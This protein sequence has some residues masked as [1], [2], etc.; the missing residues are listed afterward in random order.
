[1][2]SESEYEAEALSM[3][4]QYGQTLQIAGNGL[5]KCPYIFKEQYDIGDTITL[6]FSG[7]SA[8]AQI[9]TVTEHWTWGQYGIEFSFGKPQNDLARQLQLILKQIQKASNKTSTTSSVKYYTIPTDT[10]QP[11]A[12]VIYDTIGFQGNVGNGAAFTLYYDSEKTGAKN[13]HI[14]FKQLAGTGKLTLTTGVAGASNL[15][16]NAGTYVALIYVDA[17]GNVLSQGATATD[18]IASG[19]TQPATSSGVAGAISTE[20]TDR[21]NA[22]STAIGTIGNVYQISGT[23]L[24]MNSC[25]IDSLKNATIFYNI[26]QV[27]NPIPNS[28]L[29]DKY[30]W[31]LVTFQILYNNNLRLIQIA[32][33]QTGGNTNFLNRIFCRQGYKSYGQPSVWG[34]WVER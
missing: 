33:P 28:P 5:A 16:L 25:Y 3:L 7:K 24:N 31:N 18:T 1:M 14:W 22:I 6:A 11:K 4:T 34:A 32:I 26:L 23:M 9:L 17:N 10:S 8:K 27:D 20:V 21:N 15:V 13:Y 30:N 12:D 19:N 29:T 2:T